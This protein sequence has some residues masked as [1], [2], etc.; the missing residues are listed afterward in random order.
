MASSRERLVVLLVEV[1]EVDEQE[2][3]PEA[4]LG[5]LGIDSLGA[6]ELHANIYRRWRLALEQNDAGTEMT[7][8]EVCRR[9]D[10]A[11]GQMVR[12]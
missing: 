3:V 11:A 6:L 5:E 10:V 7:V 9:M 2:I 1:F 12:P 4:S 8:G